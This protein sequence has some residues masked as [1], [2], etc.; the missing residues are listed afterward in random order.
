[1]SVHLGDGPQGIYWQRKE[2]KITQEQLMD[3]GA[4]RERKTIFE[5]CHVSILLSC[6]PAHMEVCL[7]F[8]EKGL[9]C[10]WLD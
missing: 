9:I 2:N 3:E 5:F 4:G 10:G 6:N 1:M 7:N 8:R